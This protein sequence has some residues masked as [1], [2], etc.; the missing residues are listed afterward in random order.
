MSEK[1]PYIQINLD[2]IRENAE[3]IMSLCKGK[4]IDLWCV[5]KSFLADKRISE[6][7]L[8][9]GC[10]GLCDSRIQNLFRLRE[11]FPDAKLMSIRSPGF[12][13]L[14][15]LVKNV[16]VSLQTD[17]STINRIS[18]IAGK[19]NKKHSIILLVELGDL[20]EG[21]P[22]D[23]FLSVVQS[24]L[25]L[26]G[27]DVVGIGTTLTCLSGAIP[28][29]E[30]LGELLEM[31]KRLKNEL[32]IN[33]PIVAGGG[34][35][36]LPMLIDGELPGEINELHVGESI[37]LGTNVLTREFLPGLNADT[38]ELVAEVIECY[39]KPSKPWGKFSQNAMGE[40]PEFKD[41]G[42]RKRAILNVGK[43]DT[44]PTF[45]TPLD[46][47]VVLI[48]ASSDHMV[49]DV[50]D[51]GMIRTGCTLSL[52]LVLGAGPFDGQ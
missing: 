9:C 22:K 31:N 44:I 23:E 43:Q 4:G 48:D 21:I 49:V 20:R 8:K 38:F 15:D 12:S 39:D 51:A 24:T 16:D 1:T 28:T 41:M 30:N 18:E 52:D 6:V 10:K 33:L 14:E 36:V 5:T 13:F 27:V 3:R 2:K 11:N 40:N 17:I 26:D 50:E 37:V 46:D 34:S 29:T 32:A 25:K 42:V 35:N 45:L 47:G 7:L 19:L